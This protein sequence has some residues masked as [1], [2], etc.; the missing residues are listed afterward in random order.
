MSFKTLWFW[1][2]QQL[3]DEW[4]EVHAFS[5]DEYPKPSIITSLEKPT[6][7]QSIWFSSLDN[8]ENLFINFQDSDIVDIAPP[9]WFVLHEANSPYPGGP[10]IPF[11]FIHAMYGD[12]FAPGTIIKG[13]KLLDK[14]IPLTAVGAGKS[15]RTGYLQW[16]RESSKI[17]QITV[18]E[19]WRRKRITLVLFSVGD[20]VLLSGNIGPLLNGGDVTTQDGEK[21]RLAWA[22]S[23]RLLP[24]IGSVEN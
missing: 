24:R 15:I 1:K 22:N 9:L 19:E 14:N 3:N 23:N 5:T 17:Q 8:D 10:K 6:E 13:K 2:P 4:A 12:D 20:L 21:L 16:F 18:S 7:Q 11:V